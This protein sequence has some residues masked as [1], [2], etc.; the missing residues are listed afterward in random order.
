MDRPYGVAESDHSSTGIKDLSLAK[1]VGSLLTL[2]ALLSGVILLAAIA[3]WLR[4]LAP[5]RKRLPKHRWRR[6]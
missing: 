2:H 4:W 3:G 6:A 1:I 5:G